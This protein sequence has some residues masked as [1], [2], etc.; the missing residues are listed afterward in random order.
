MIESLNVWPRRKRHYNYL[1]ARQMWLRGLILRDGG[2]P[3]RFRMCTR[4]GR[5]GIGSWKWKRGRGS[6]TR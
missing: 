2:I 1:K 3:V 5:K 4:H 6:Y